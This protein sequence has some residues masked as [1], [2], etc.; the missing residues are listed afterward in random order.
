MA[1][2]KKVGRKTKFDK[3]K[4]PQMVHNYIESCVDEYERIKKAEQETAKSTYKSYDHRLFAK[5]PTIEWLANFMELNDD[6]IYEWK[7]KRT[8]ERNEDYKPFSDAID[9]L[10][11]TQKIK[12]IE[13]GLWGNYNPTITK[14]LLASNHGL[15]DKKDVSHS[16][17]MTNKVVFSEELW[18]SP[19]VEE[20]NEDNED[21][22]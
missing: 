5:I 19:F 21:L 6:T 1:E 7:K 3:E 12:L 16:G 15:S 8:E 4:S 17:E 11:R 10:K 2:E 18:K 22:P 13:N 14:L 20:D 9:K